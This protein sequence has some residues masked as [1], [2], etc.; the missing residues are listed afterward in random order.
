MDLYQHLGGGDGVALVGVATV[1]GDFSWVWFVVVV[2]VVVDA[3]GVILLW[4]CG[5]GDETTMPSTWEEQRSDTKHASCA[6]CSHLDH[7]IFWRTV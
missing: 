5:G 2:V 4:M 7:V 1:A 3:G 6:V